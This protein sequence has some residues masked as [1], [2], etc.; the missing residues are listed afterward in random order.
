MAKSNSIC[1]SQLSQHSLATPLR[2]LLLGNYLNAF[3]QHI[4]TFQNKEC[5]LIVKVKEFSS[6]MLN[7]VTLS[8]QAFSKLLKC[9]RMGGKPEV[10]NAERGFRSLHRFLR[11]LRESAIF[12]C[13]LPRCGPQL[14]K[15]WIALST[16]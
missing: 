15:R 7:K 9:K 1:I 5:P 14:F 8:T 6:F 3:F 10:K 16:V 11:L 12:K 2:Q 13:Y 4:V